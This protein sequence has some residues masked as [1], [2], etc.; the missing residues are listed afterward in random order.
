MELKH[1]YSNYCNYFVIETK[2]HQYVV[3]YNISFYGVLNLCTRIVIDFGHHCIYKIKLNEKCLLQRTTD[4]C[5]NYSNVNQH[6]KLAAQPE[7]CSG[8]FG[9]ADCGAGGGTAGGVQGFTSL[10]GR[11]VNSP[12]T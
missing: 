2:Q 5:H 6:V 11:F 7:V 1:N 4:V 9:G 12:G 8:N 3:F 10:C